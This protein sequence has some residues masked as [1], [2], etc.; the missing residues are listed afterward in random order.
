[1]LLAGC[2]G[3]RLHFAAVCAAMVA[4]SL[5]VLA[6]TTQPAIVIAAYL[7]FAGACFSLTMLMTIS[8]TEVP[9]MRELAVGLA[10]LNTVSQVGAFV[11]PYL[12]GRAKDATGSH[13]AGL[14][15]L[16]VALLVNVALILA[17]RVK[18]HARQDKRL[19]TVIA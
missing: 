5:A 1:M 13:H 2:V 11:M 17:V 18:A 3:D 6:V 8:W 10:A 19:L 14:I 16:S 4:G 15:G 12:W 9:H 7:S